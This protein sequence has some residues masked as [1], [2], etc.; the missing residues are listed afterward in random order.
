MLHS[1]SR[2]RLIRSE[3]PYENAAIAP[4]TPPD[5]L[6]RIQLKISGSLHQTS[7]QCLYLRIKTGIGGKRSV[8]LPAQQP[9]DQI[10]CDLPGCA[11]DLLFHDRLHIRA[12]RRIGRGA[13]DR[14]WD[15]P[16]P[17]WR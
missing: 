2:T 16:V 6:D 8:L 15:R 17:D 1:P 11:L 5:K 4:L 3:W 13:T 14:E 9:V 12:E 10:P 7:R